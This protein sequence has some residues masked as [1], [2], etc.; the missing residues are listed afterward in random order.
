MTADAINHSHVTLSGPGF[1]G[2]INAMQVLASDETRNRRLVGWRIRVM[3]IP[4]WRG[5]D[6]YFVWSPAGVAVPGGACVGVL[7]F[8]GCVVEAEGFGDDGGGGLEDELAQGGDPC[9]AHGE[10]EAA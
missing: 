6:C 4:V 5:R 8:G 7:A 3:R 10:A 1:R 9:G 2:I